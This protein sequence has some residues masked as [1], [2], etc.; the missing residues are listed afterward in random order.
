ML[1]RLFSPALSFCPLSFREVIMTLAG[2]PRRDEN[3]LVVGV[4]TSA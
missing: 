2:P 3:G 4:Q 1:S